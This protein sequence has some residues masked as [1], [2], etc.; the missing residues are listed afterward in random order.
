LQFGLRY[1]LNLPVEGGFVN[2]GVEQVA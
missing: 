1:D 2:V